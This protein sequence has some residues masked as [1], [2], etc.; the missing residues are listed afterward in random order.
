MMYLAYQAQSDMMEPVRSMADLVV[1]G[2]TREEAERALELTRR[3]LATLRLQ[4]NEQKTRVVAYTD[5]LEFL[6]QALAP[7]PSGPRLGQG[8][9]SF[10]EAERA[11]REVS[12]QAG[13][14]VRQSAGQMRQGAD[15][16]RR[17][18]TRKP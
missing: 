11:L 15:A 9:T 13:A 14:R 18:I 10:E 2:A 16:I 7:R 8:L 17:R 4:L 1:M 3:Q 12:H 6:G 5:G